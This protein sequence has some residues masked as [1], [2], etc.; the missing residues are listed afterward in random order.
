MNAKT[1]T[2]GLSP[3]ARTSGVIV[4]G[5]VTLALRAVAL[6]AFVLM[7]LAEPFVAVILGVLALACFLVAVL[8]GF[9]LRMPFQHRWDVLG[10]SVLFVVAYLL[11]RAIMLGVQRLMR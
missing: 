2:A 5:V 7:S 8:F 6:M 3:A 1:L 10:A 11:F 4:A 9:I